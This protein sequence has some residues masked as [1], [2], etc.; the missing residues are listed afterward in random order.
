MLYTCM[1][2]GRDAYGCA[3]KNATWLQLSCCEDTTVF[4]RAV[5]K[6]SAA[7]LLRKVQMGVH[8]LA[9]AANIYEDGDS[10]SLHRG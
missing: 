3:E 1:L 6:L 9:V 5:H 7:S 2:Q 10:V 8:T 4:S